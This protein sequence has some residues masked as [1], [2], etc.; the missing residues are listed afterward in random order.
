[1]RWEDRMEVYTPTEAQCR[2]M[3]WTKL[4]PPVVGTY[5]IYPWKRDD[6]LS[7]WPTATRARTIDKDG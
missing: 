2:Q 4:D 7:P 3:G 5:G 6:L 1:M